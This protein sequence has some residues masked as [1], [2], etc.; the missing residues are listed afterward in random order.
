[1]KQREREMAV[2]HRQQIG[3]LRL[4]TG[5]AGVADVA[6]VV[7]AMLTTPVAARVEQ[8]SLLAARVALLQM[9]AQRRRAR[10]ARRE[11][12]TCSGPARAGKPVRRRSTSARVA[13]TTAAQ[14]LACGEGGDGGV[15]G[16]LGSCDSSNSSNSSDS[17]DSASPPNSVGG[18]G[19]A[20]AAAGGTR[21]RMVQQ[22]A[23][24]IQIDAGLLQMGGEAVP[25]RMDAA[26]LG[27]AG[28][29]AGQTVVTLCPSGKAA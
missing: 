6:G 7:L 28:G 14:C 3:Q 1:M 20:Q 27:D 23:D 5:V 4:A 16:S 9:T 21:V 2:R 11:L 26:D 12:A 15:V 19:P 10:R 13:L 8:P 25:Q 18:P 22:L 29:G 24:A 17:S